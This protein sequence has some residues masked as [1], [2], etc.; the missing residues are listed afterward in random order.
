MG[1][2]LQF[3]RHQKRKWFLRRR[4]GVSYTRRENCLCVYIFGFDHTF[5]PLSHLWTFFQFFKNVSIFSFHLNTYTHA[6]QIRKLNKTIELFLLF[7][8]ETNDQQT[9]NRWISF[10]LASK[11]L[12]TD[13]SLSFSTLFILWV[14][15]SRLTIDVRPVV[16]PSLDSYSQR[17][18]P[19]NC[20]LLFCSFCLVWSN[21]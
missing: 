5:S 11:L 14:S 10:L 8:S 2:G 1:M 6:F 21:I 16:R 19:W 9:L 15:V 13:T 4:F 20:H 18:I 3:R 7:Y 17:K 12:V